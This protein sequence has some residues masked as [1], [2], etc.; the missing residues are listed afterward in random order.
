M[1]EE[2]AAQVYRL[3]T[4][5]MPPSSECTRTYGETRPR[6][7]GMLSRL[8][9]GARRLRLVCDGVAVEQQFPQAMICA[10]CL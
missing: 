2:R 5:A 10:R 6:F 8:F 3:R 1:R 9:F 7:R 4:T